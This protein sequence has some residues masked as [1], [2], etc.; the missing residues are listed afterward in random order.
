ME[1]DLD[2]TDIRFR[3]LRHDDLPLLHRWLNTPHVLEWWDRPGPTIE[4]VGEKYSPRILRKER[5]HPYVALLEGIP[6][7][8]IQVYEVEA[9]S[10]Y[11]RYLPPGARAFGVDLFIGE[12]GHVH[13]GLGS[14]LLRAFVDRVIFGQTDADV[15][16]IDP[17]ERNRIAIRAYEK[18][19]FRH[20]ATFQLP[21]EEDPTYLM[22]LPP[23]RGE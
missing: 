15:C 2:A 5:V 9:D 10:P 13:R 23:L 12:P 18:A 8:Y 6:L 22:L 3:P 1:R 16:V 19:G 21:D 17:S 7:G 11:A 20:V 4:Q 14:R